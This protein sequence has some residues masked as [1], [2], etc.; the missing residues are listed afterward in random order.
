[1]VE[2]ALARLALDAVLAD[3]AL[4]GVRDT[5]FALL[6]TFAFALITGGG[7][8]NDALPLIGDGGRA[9]TGALGLE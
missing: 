8:D 9:Y 1:M 5:T 2:V 4:D 6:F 3:G 7:G